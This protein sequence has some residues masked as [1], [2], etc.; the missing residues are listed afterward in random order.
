MSTK[1]IAVANQKGG[2]AKTTTTNNV[3]AI[4]ASKHGYKVLCIDMD[5]QA[6][7]TDNS[8]ADQNKALDDVLR[9]K[10]L[11][12]ECIQHTKNYDILASSISLAAMEQEM[13]GMMGRECKLDEAI[14]SD[15]KMKEYDYILIDTPPALGNLTVASLVAA[16]KVIIPT[17]ADA[18]STRG[19]YQL[20]QTIS[21]VRKYFNKNL[22]IVGILFTRY[23]PRLK[24]S[25]AIA[26]M[27]KKIANMLDTDVFETFIRQATVVS[28]AS[29]VRQSVTEWE[30]KSTVAQDYDSLVA[31][32]LNKK[33]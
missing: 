5:P 28:E 4:L 33:I 1:I 32:L 3:A 10:L 11:I 12:S 7:L 18:N 15:P 14:Q 6:N 13:M 27:A 23:N 19:I 21:N 25:Q 8:A 31:E 16:Q 9:G 30:K 29:Y 24:I 2:V 22:E 17:M 26:P 20:G